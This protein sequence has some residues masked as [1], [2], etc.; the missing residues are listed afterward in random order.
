MV[1]QYKYYVSGHYPSSCLYLKTPSCLFFKTQ[2]FGD[3]ILSSSSGKT[4]GCPEIGTSSIEWAR[5]S[6]FYLKR[7]TEYSLRNVVFKK[8]KQDGVLG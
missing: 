2:R 7:E 3:W 5:L 1:H 4:Y 6:R 8:N